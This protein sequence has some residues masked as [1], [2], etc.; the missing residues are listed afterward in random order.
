MNYT[1]KTLHS[2]K[3][4][5]IRP[6]TWEEYWNIN[7][8]RLK[9]SQ[10]ISAD[11][12]EKKDE[13]LFLEKTR[14]IREKPLNYCVQGWAELKLELSLSEVLELEKHIDDVSK[15]PVAEGNS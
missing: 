15:A 4:V 7:L 1:E 9:M 12:H 2:G 8:E 11:P 3:V 14:T 13:V 6:L 10:D 5:Q